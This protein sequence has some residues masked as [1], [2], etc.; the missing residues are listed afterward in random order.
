ML[1]QFSENTS[2]L[3]FKKMKL[4]KLFLKFI[5]KN[6]RIARKTLK[7]KNYEMDKIYQTLK[8]TRKSL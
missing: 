8:H 6:L 3:F 1:I 5:F 2:K 4:D 7:G